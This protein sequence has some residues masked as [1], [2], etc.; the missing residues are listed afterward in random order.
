MDSEYFDRLWSGNMSTV[1]ESRMRWELRAKD[2]NIN[3][4]QEMIRYVVGFFIEKGMLCKDYDVID[5]GCGTG[6]Y[7]VELSKISKSVT[8]LDF[9]P[10]MLEFAKENAA[11]EGVTNVEFL[12]M[13]WEEAD[14]DVLGW[15]KRFDFAAA[16]MSPAINSRKSLEKLMDVSKG[17][18]FMSGHLNRHE[19][20][21]EQIERK[22]LQRE[23]EAIDYGRNIYCSFNI[24]WQYGIHPELKYYDMKREITRPLEE[25]FRFY[26]SQLQREKELSGDE[27]QAIKQYLSKISE[28]GVVKGI[29]ESKTAWLYW[30]NK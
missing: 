27:K 29:F 15:K 6:K 16:I 24:L 12:E 28:D 5:I 13:P 26:C 20:I 30:E 23:P 19:R 11:R 3:K 21:R 18:C 25:A 17:Y 7:A 10:K 4:H 14:L 2:F 1:E 8:A 22:V 9:S